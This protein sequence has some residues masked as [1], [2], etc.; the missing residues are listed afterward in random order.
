MKGKSLCFIFVIFIGILVC[1]SVEAMFCGI[2]GCD[3]ETEGWKKQQQQ[4]RSS[5]HIV[6]ATTG[7]SRRRY[8]H[9]LFGEDKRE[10]DEAMRLAG[11]W[12]ETKVSR[13]LV[14]GRQS[15]QSSHSTSSV[16]VL[17]HDLQKLLDQKLISL[18]Q[19]R[20][21]MLPPEEET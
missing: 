14:G 19:A 8:Y 4:T 13:S 7:I 6:D 3:E 2:F 12:Y 10:W 21:M 5:T 1:E 20:Q 16:R 11:I 18:E 15:R 9:E 17:T